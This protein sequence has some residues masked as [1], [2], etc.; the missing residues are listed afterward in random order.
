M[1]MQRLQ[2]AVTDFL[3]LKLMV[4]PNSIKKSALTRINRCHL[5]A[6]PR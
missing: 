5:C 2:A 1:L 4:L 3:H 6:I